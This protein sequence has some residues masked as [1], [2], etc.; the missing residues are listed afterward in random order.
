MEKY[1]LN[2][3]DHDLYIYVYRVV[4]NVLIY[5]S[6]NLTSGV[7]RNILHPHLFTTRLQN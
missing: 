6:E 7:K 1:D 5:Q 3:F 4:L 2:Y